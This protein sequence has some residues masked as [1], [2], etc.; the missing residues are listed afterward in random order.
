MLKDF[1][2]RT[3]LGENRTSIKILG[4]PNETF[5]KNFDNFKIL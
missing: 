5:L 1:F 4:T 3:I 2:Y